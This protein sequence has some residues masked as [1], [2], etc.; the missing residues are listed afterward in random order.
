[1]VNGRQVNE[2]SRRFTRA[3]LAIMSMIS[4]VLWVAAAR[5][6]GVPDDLKTKIDAFTGGV[7]TRV[8]WIKQGE[9]WEDD[10]FGK[11]LFGYDS[12]LD[13]VDTIAVTVDTRQQREGGFFRP[14]LCSGGH[15]VVFADVG[16]TYVINWDG[17]GRRLISDYQLSDA[18]KDPAT[19]K[20]YVFVQTS[21]G[22]D[23]AG[24]CIRINID[25]PEDQ[26]VLIVEQFGSSYISWYQASADG[27]LAVDFMP[28]HGGD[29]GGSCTV[30]D[31]ALRNGGYKS[32]HGGGCRSSVEV[33][34]DYI[35][36]KMQCCPHAGVQV[37][38][39]DF[40]EPDPA[41]RNRRI[42][43]GTGKQMVEFN[44]TVPPGTDPRD[45]ANPKFAS[46]G[47]GVMCVVGGLN[48]DRNL[49]E[50]FMHKFAP[51][52]RSFT[53]WVQLTEGLG[54]NVFPDVWIGVE[55][56]SPEIVLSSPK[57]SFYAY[58]DGS[59]PAPQ[60]M[61]VQ[62]PFG[63]LSDV[64]AHED[65]SWL[66][67]EVTGTGDS[68]AIENRISVGNLG[69]GTQSATVTVS[70]S[71]ADVEPETYVVELTIREPQDPQSITIVPA[72]AVVKT[73]GT[74][75]F[76]ATILDQ[77]DQPM[78][79]QPAFTWS[80][81]DGGTISGSGVFTAGASLGGPYTVTAAALGVQGMAQV[82]VSRNC[83]TQ[84]TVN[85]K[86]D[87]AVWNELGTFYFL[88]GGGGHVLITNEGANGFVVAD[89]VRFTTGDT[90]V[91]VDNADASQVE[92]TGTWTSSS[93]M[94]GYHGDDYIHDGNEGQGT[95]SVKFT[96]ELPRDGDYVVSMMWTAHDSRADN[97]AVDIVN[98]C[99]AVADEPL[100]LV[101]PNGDR[102][103]AVG[104]TMS[105]AWTAGEEVTGILAEISVDRGRT[106]LPITQ[107]AA[108][109]PE[110]TPYEWT[111][112]AGLD[113]TS[114]VSDSVVV[115]VS[116]YFVTTIWDIS[117]ASFSITET[118]AGHVPGGH[119]AGRVPVIA[120]RGMLVHIRPPSDGPYSAT[121][122]RI[123]GS[124]VLVERGRSARSKP[125]DLRALP[126]GVYRLR[127]E[128]RGG[129]VQSGIVV[130]R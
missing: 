97:V 68:Y 9:Q 23:P 129:S 95:K 87:G 4:L 43:G 74:V 69:V 86:T 81:E 70:A 46:K 78:I 83:A 31:G 103:Y 32:C 120:R 63:T 102:S 22:G 116:D 25:D 105:I 51:D 92:L 7:H 107:D 79:P 112:P 127:V 100:T 36:T 110:S 106:W 75:A 53:D 21:R 8:V 27:R 111:I 33:S 29:D 117:D 17:T 99:G 65:A 10:G 26:L 84:M 91:I 11:Y 109:A 104:E 3:R 73:A 82:T 88:R 60:T 115:R 24:E 58:P 126:S 41:L 39:Y 40:D 5:S 49:V 28:W 128:Y 125:V 13:M 1:M 66:S 19:G 113:G 6:S 35:W 52:Y 130:C 90:E 45:W 15:R 54:G 59:D 76:A 89:A 2:G 72:S 61:T 108:W 77:Y 44:A 80:V 34:N 93:A 14:V 47:K 38:Q 94:M 50:S 118:G 85:Q 56:T 114:L 57:L 121:V 67:V 42:S 124:R 20:E 30:E 16:K 123:D 12:K 119:T 96:P 122:F 98:D 64:T 55:A 101:S 18:W 48:G 37:F 71:N 62:T